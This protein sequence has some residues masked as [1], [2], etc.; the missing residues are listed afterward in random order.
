MY[1][2]SKSTFPARAVMLIAGSA[3]AAALSV[4]MVAD[5]AVRNVDGRV[6]DHQTSFAARGLKAEVDR[7]AVEQHAVTIWDEAVLAIQASDA[8]WLD[9][10]LGI[11]MQTFYGHDQEYILGPDDR[12]IYAAIERK[13][14]V[15]DSVVLDQPLVDFVR[16]LRVKMKIAREGGEDPVESVKGLAVAAPLLLNNMPAIASVVPIVPSSKRV[17]YMPESEYLHVAVQYLDKEIAQRIAH[18]YDFSDP[19]FLKF[20]PASENEDKLS[21]PVPGADDKIV[22]W[23]AWDADKPGVLLVRELAPAVVFFGIF[24]LTV[25]IS[26]IARL[27]FSA[28]NLQESETE[29][30]YL[31]N[32]DPLAGVPNRLNFDGRLASA[33]QAERAGGQAVTLLNIDLDHFKKVN[34]AL[35]HAA[36]DELIRQVS[37]RMQDLIR[38]TDTVARIGGDEFAIILIG[39]SD[40]DALSSFCAGLVHILS[41]PYSLKAGTAQVS[42]SIGVAR[43]REFDGGVEGLQRAADAALYRAKADGRSRFC[44]FTHEMEDLLR[45]RHEIERDLRLAI[46]SGDQL[47]LFF[48]PI[49]NQNGSLFGAEALARWPGAPN[50]P[51]SPDIFIGIA[52]ES[53]LIEEIGQW[54]LKE[55]CA[56]ARATDL[57]KVCVNVSG[58]QL[59][60][61]KFADEVLRI[62]GDSGLAPERLE[63]EL[64]ERCALDSGSTTHENLKALRAAGVTVALDDFATGHSLLQYVRDFEIDVIK[65]DQS[66]VRQ[67][68]TGDGTD[69]VVRALVDLGHAMGL[70]IVAEGVET[71]DQRDT[72]IR[73]G[74][75][76]FQGFLLG[77]PISREEFQGRYGTGSV[78]SP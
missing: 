32:H 2:S 72:L 55:A 70:K 23:L 36:G 57:S 43:A 66:F 63:L 50:G 71:K 40:G 31:A 48:Q 30:R 75:R 69:Q 6:A 8:L 12:P 3:L 65:I 74:C 38:P 21:L 1:K 33:L 64:T 77:G 27:W 10:N 20:D 19:A 29:A 49:V 22:A 76:V 46:K 53:G 18:V 52:E 44:I 62:L 51:V 41:L 16:E 15:L 28:R 60:S 47:D 68:G 35:G 9:G 61:A 13:R 58:V 34:D 4:F 24:C 54:V 73:I 5:E 26:L 59:Q 14:A 37:A 17:A 67:L 39:L 42:A 56:F 25:F 78:V 11:W 45:R 7:L